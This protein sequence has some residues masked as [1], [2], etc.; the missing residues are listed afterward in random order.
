MLSPQFQGRALVRWGIIGC[1]DV[2]EQKSGPGFRHARDSALVAV[3]RRNGALAAD[4]AR[5]HQVPRWY[6]DAAR[7][8]ADPE[9]DAVCIATPPDTHAHYALLAAAAGKPAYVEKPM[10]RHTP[11]CDRMIAAFAAAGQKLFVAYYRRSLPRWQRVQELIA[12]QELGRLT[13]VHYRLAMPKHHGPH[14]WRTCVEQAGGGHFLDLASHALDLIDFLVGPLQ[15]VHGHAANL[16]S[17]YAAEDC[18]TGSFLA[19]EVPGTIAC[20]FAAALPDEQL[21]ITGTKGEVR[22][23]VLGHEPVVVETAAGLQRWDMPPPPHIAQP[24]IQACVDDLLGRDT[25]PSTGETA[26]RT[27]AVMDT[28]LGAYYGGRQDEFWLRPETWPGRRG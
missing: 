6:D 5:R 8:L 28:L 27:S 14:A 22:V 24:L 15:A 1:G 10:A 23:T 7:L 20:N 12:A 17:S 3:M 16:A 2:T 4:Y 18:V 19:G 9:V 26:R 21:T 11:E 25:A 13:G